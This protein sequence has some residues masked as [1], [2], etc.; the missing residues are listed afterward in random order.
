[1]ART[2]N[3]RRTRVL[4]QPE[5]GAAPAA[6]QETPL[7]M[8]KVVA[9]ILLAVVLQ[10]TVAPY[11]TVLG[12]RPDATLVVVICL[13]MMRGPLWGAVV[14]FSTGLLIDIS[15]VQTMGI[16]S[17]L[18]TLSG[19]FSGRLAERVDPA[20][21]FPPLLIVFIFSLM[22]QLLYAMIMFLLGV[23]ASVGF[24]L[25]RVVLPTAFLNGLLAAPV[26]AVCRWWLGNDNRE[27][28]FT[29]KQ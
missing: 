21:W 14:G 4:S 28:V 22:V 2:R 1:M 20:S 8:L 15:L 9:V 5:D 18:F 19:Y 23:E 26:Y 29:A 27:N 12:A 6:V 3:L 7:S 10:T 25:L 17:F 13:A 16:S 11:L 24:V